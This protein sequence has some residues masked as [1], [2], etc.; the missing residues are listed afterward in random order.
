MK[1]REKQ[2]AETR[3]AILEAVAVEI[4][5]SGLTGFSIQGVA[6]RAGVTHRTVYN[7]F[8]TREA[9]NDAFAEYV[10]QVLNERGMGGEERGVG[11]D[12]LPAITG[13]MHSSYGE[14]AAYLQAYVM[15]TIATG[16][17]ARVFR[18]RSKKMEKLIDEQLGPLEPGVAKLVTSAVRLFLSSAGWFLV[19]QHHGLSP[20]E[21]GRMSEWAVKVLLDAA[22]RGNL[23]KRV[24]KKRKK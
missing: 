14:N 13:Q 3:R 7:H 18:E 1:L 20:D 4:V 8:P 6:D 19:K 21:A 15:M 2:M 16:K 17:A 11:V 9:L 22:R 23:P 5:E 10:E 24:D 12:Q